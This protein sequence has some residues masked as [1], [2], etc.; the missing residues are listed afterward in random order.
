MRDAADPRTECGAASGIRARVRRGPASAAARGTRARGGTCAGHF[1][2]G[3]QSMFQ[4]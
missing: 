4:P 2:P 1:L 3:D